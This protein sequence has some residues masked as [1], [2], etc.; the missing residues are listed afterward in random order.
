[1][2]NVFTYDKDM[3]YIWYIYKDIQIW[4][5][6]NALH[7]YCALQFVPDIDP[8]IHTFIYAGNADAMQGNSQHVR[9]ST[10]CICGSIANCVDLILQSTRVQNNCGWRY[11]QCEAG[12]LCVT[13]SIDQ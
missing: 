4:C 12:Y 2:Q 10:V 5:T 6:V 9:S 13:H 11:T 8:F 3:V 1:M 7:L